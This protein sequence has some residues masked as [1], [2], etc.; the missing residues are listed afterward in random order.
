M[1]R[2][3]FAYLGTSHKSGNDISC[4]GA[5]QRGTFVYLS[6]VREATFDCPRGRYLE[7]VGGSTL[8]KIVIEGV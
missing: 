3:F 2:F 6:L 5:Y 4:S 1:E 8:L 7:A